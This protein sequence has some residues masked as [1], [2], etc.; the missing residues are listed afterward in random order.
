M[1]ELLEARRELHCR[2]A[3]RCCQLRH[4]GRI[5]EIF[6][7]EPH[8]I[9]ARDLIA[10]RLDIHRALPSASSGWISDITEWNRMKLSALNRNH[11]PR[12][13]FEQIVD[14]RVAEV[15]R[16]FGVVRNR[17]RAAQLLADG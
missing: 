14:C 7:A 12:S 13:A 2:Q 10:L 8:H 5:A 16:I 15:A 11:R 3:S 4:P 17:R 6:R 9:I 1:R